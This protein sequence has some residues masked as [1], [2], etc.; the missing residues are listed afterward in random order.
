LL[1]ALY[2][3][4]VFI[5]ALLVGLCYKGLIP[6]P[7][8]AIIVGRDVAL[9]IGSFFL[10][11]REIPAGAPFFDTTYSATFKITPSIL[12]KVSVEIKLNVL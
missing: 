5:G 9:I 10:R 11:F 4:F 7:L 1:L 2:N 3:I 8:A 12:G 6:L